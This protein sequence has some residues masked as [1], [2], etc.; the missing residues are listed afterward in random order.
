CTTRRGTTRSGGPRGSRTAR[1]MVTSA[2]STSS[3]RCVGTAWAMVSA[4]GVTREGVVSQLSAAGVTLPAAPMPDLD[5]PFHNPTRIEF[6]FAKLR[7]VV[8]LLQVRHRPGAGLRW[9]INHDRTG[10]AWA[11]AEEGID[12]Q[13]IV[14]EASAD[15][16]APTTNPEDDA[17]LLDWTSPPG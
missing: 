8:K 10:R 7:G 4:F 13:A 14:D 9:G 11:F 12:L 3:W 15:P 6:P 16:P 1:V 17:H 2:R 5:Q